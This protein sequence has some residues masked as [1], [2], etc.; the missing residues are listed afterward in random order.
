[1]KNARR[2]FSFSKMKYASCVTHEQPGEGHTNL[3]RMEEESIFT[4]VKKHIKTSVL[5]EL[6]PETNLNK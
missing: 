5:W 1:M 3:S 2:L 4:E 6:G